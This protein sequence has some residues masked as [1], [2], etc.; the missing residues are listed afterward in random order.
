MCMNCL[1]RCPAGRITFA[2]KPS[3]AG[4]V[5]LPD[6]SRRGFIVA[7]SGLVL[8]SMWGVGGLAGA[9][10]DASLIRPPGALDE[11]RF[12]A[13]CIRCGQCMLAAN[14]DP[15]VVPCPNPEDPTQL[16]QRHVVQLGSLLRRLSRFRV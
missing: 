1:D 8:A 16:E 14:L 9:N 13:R 2:G 12:L 3:A 6:L 15:T 5:G 4:E 7:G 10:R 11:A